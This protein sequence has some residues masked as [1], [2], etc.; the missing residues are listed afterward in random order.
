IAVTDTAEA[1][2]LVRALRVLPSL[3]AAELFFADGLALVCDHSRLPAP[4]AHDYPVYV[5]VECAGRVDP[6]DELL[7]ALE[8]ATGVRDATVASDARGREALWR[9][10]EAHTESINAAGVPL[11]LDVAV[12]LG[13]FADCVAAL[14]STVAAAAPDARVILFGH[15]NEG[16]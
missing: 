2:E 3:E 12:P 15:I 9:Y 5:V 16:N 11:K 6:T 7:A 10:R 1:V 4:F 8:A 14:P 13:A